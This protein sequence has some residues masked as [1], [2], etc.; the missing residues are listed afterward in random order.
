MTNTIDNLTLR[1]VDG[2]IASETGKNLI[3][4]LFP[5]NYTAPVIKILT[6]VVKAPCYVLIN[7]EKVYVDPS[8]GLNYHNSFKPIGQLEFLDAGIMYHMAYGV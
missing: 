3:K 2:W 1:T 5:P 8:L 6:L 4:E 7:G